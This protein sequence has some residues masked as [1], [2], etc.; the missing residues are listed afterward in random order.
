[1]TI[2]KDAVSRVV[3]AIGAPHGRH[4]AAVPNEASSGV[5][6]LEAPLV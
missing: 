2:P 5:L 4:H 3:D 6:V 1:M